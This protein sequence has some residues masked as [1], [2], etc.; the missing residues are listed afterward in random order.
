MIKQLLFLSIPFV[1]TCCQHQEKEKRL[2]N[3]TA[4]KKEFLLSILN[5]TEEENPFH[6]N[7]K[8]RTVFFSNEIISLFGEIQI[9]D[10]LPHGSRTY[11]G[12]TFCK[13]DGDYKEIK[14]SDLFCTTAQ[15]EFLRLYCETDLKSQSNSY[16]S[17][18]DPLRSTLEYDDISA[19]VIDG[20]HLIV[21]FSPYIAGG[22]EDTPLHVKVPF[23]QLQH[24]WDTSNP[25]PL[26]IRKT[27]LH[28]SYTSTW[29]DNL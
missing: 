7:Y 27:L 24:Q 25:L 13:I 3:L 12:K 2:D 19:F 17:S 18:P 15:K 21:L 23:E 26:L 10:H 29:D 16:F 14:L 6:M 9:Y 28:N 8:L 11:E 4:I 22:F 5:Q 20:K 1:A